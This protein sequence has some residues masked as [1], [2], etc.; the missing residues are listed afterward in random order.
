[1]EYL[2]T[3]VECRAFCFFYLCNFLTLNKLQFAVRGGLIAKSVNA[4]TAPIPIKTLQHLFCSAG[5]GI[6]CGRE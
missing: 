4:Q 3:V 5:S 6:F 2:F 1:M